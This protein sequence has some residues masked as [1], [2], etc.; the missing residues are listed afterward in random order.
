M[1]ILE[2]ESEGSLFTRDH[3]Y[4]SQVKLL[5]SN[6]N[7]N[8]VL[9]IF[10]NEKLTYVRF[11][12]KEKNFVNYVPNYEDVTSLVLELFKSAKPNKKRGERSAT[13]SSG[14]FTVH[15]DDNEELLSLRFS[16]YELEVVHDEP[17]ETI[18]VV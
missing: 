3:S 10:E 16:P 8:S 12:E 18:F 15:W 11:D 17:N 1:D 14:L 2:P 4:E 5:M 9:R 13:V 6:F 7:W